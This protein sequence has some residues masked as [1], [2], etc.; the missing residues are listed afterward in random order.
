M[1]S[2][3]RYEDLLNSTSPA[4]Q[5][6]ESY[7]LGNGNIGIMNYGNIDRNIISINDDRL[8]SGTG[9]NKNN[10]D[11]G[12]HLEEI[13]NAISEGNLSIAE[14]LTKSHILGDWSESYLPLADIIIESNISKV[15]GYKRTLDMARGIHTVKF[16]SPNGEYFNESFVS[17]PNGCY[18]ARNTSSNPTTYSFAISS[19]LNSTLNINCDGAMVEI[20]ISG[21]APTVNQPVYRNFAIPTEYV[22][23]DEG[24]DWIAK[25]RIV[26]NGNISIE[27]DIVTITDCT[28]YQLVMTTDVKFRTNKDMEQGTTRRV[29]AVLAKPYSKILE[30]HVL[31]HSALYNRCFLEI[32]GDHTN[33]PT[34]ELLKQNNKLKNNKLVT[35]L[36]NF[37]RYLTI[38]SSRPDTEAINLQGIWN[39][40]LQPPWSSN[41]TINI[42]TEMNYW[43]TLLV[44][45]TD[46]HLPMIDLIK[47]I[48]KNGKKTAAE[49]YGMSG[50][51]C[52]HNSDG[53]GLSNPVGSSASINSVVFGLFLGGAGWLCRH[54]YE[55]FL[56]TDDVAFL[57]DNF[58]IL[59]DAGIFYLD[60]LSKDS[61]DGKLVCS[62]SASPENHFFKKGVHCINKTSAMDI[63]IIRELFEN[64]VKCS[65][66]LQYKDSDGII[67]NIEKTIP[68]LI[69]VGVNKRGRVMEWAENYRE[70]DIHHRHI[71]H[72][73]GCYPSDQWTDTKTPSLM[74]AV[75]KSLKRRGIN[76]TGWSI[77]WKINVFARLH[78]SKNAYKS[79]MKQLTFVKSNGSLKMGGGGTYSSMLCAHPP[80]QIDGNFGA[81]AGIA[82]MLMQSHDG[83]IELL[84]ALPD[85]FFK[86][87]VRG[88]IARGG[89]SVSL[90]WFNNRLVSYKITHP[91]KSTAIVKTNG[92]IQ[93][94]QIKNV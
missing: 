61:E 80:F 12:K 37:G 53:W 41:Y 10:S 76:G 51:T 66:I 69:T 14:D 1:R 45:L 44:G 58:N 25:C 6:E 4:I 56:F 35:I 42:N 23:G 77:A 86:G 29:K 85:E 94:I 79:I 93:E 28:N 60:Y 88:L 91:T 43:P 2:K 84:P 22:V 75:A 26:S 65:D 5:W 34:D 18:V 73:Y 82:E 71:S 21:I 36:F 15:Y 52:G 59:L 62:P 54:V 46:C 32:G 8:W 83:F 30:R 90:E 64:I 39:N 11:G 27:G 16:N 78:D 63:T 20:T 33:L 81:C 92:V 87:K 68:E 47:K 50:W 19:K 40:L 7:P 9:R 74:T 17:A 13:R 89:Y 49:T 57:S 38:A 67:E 48:Y 55:H 70:T 31:D 72:L 24:K 3:M